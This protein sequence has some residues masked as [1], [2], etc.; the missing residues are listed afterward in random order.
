M[1]ASSVGRNA[2]RPVGLRVLPSSPQTVIPSA[3]RL[4]AAGKADTI[5]SA[6]ATTCP[7][8]PTTRSA[9]VSRA[10][11]SLDVAATSSEDRCQQQQR[12]D[13]PDRGDFDTAPAGRDHQVVHAFILREVSVDDRGPDRIEPFVEQLSQF[14]VEIHFEDLAEVRGPE[15]WKTQQFGPV[16]RKPRSIRAIALVRVRCGGVCRRWCSRCGDFWI[17]RWIAVRGGQGIHRVSAFSPGGRGVRGAV[18]VVR[19]GATGPAFVRAGCRGSCG[20]ARRSAARQVGGPGPCAGPGVFG[21]RGP[22][23]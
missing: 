2:T 6:I 3:V 8:T 12:R 9:S 11:A 21:G 17:A 13:P 5:P 22:S 18:V 7:V 15:A 23:P 20:S 19:V 10:M 16:I 14:V 1:I 4:Q